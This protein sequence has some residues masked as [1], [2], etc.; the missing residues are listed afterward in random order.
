MNETIREA[1]MNC[2]A[3]QTTWTS[4][5]V[6]MEL[7]TSSLVDNSGPMPMNISR[8]DATKGGGKKGNP[9]YVKGP[10][11]G[12]KGHPWQ[13]KHDKGGKKGQ[14]WQFKGDKGGKK[15]IP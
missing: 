8:V 4:N 6:H 15:G 9:W 14:P 10:E 2:E 1:V 5:R 3:V 13:F 11:G 12:K 7:G